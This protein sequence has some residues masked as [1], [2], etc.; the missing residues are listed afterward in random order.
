MKKTA[1]LNAALSRLVATLG[2]GDMI[3]V[4]DAGMPAPRDSGV[5]WI[6]LALTPGTPSLS[7]TLAALMAEMQVESHIIASETLMREDLWVDALHTLPIG[8]RRVVSHAELKQMSTQ[9][10]AFVR[11]GECT[12]Y[13]NLMLVA[14][15]TF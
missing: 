12:P 1:L 9:A 10:R 15:V 14:G 2:H 4:A 8:V 5:E 11:T 13:A 6:D 7:V 3:L